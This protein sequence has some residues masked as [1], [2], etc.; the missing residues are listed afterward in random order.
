MPLKEDLQKII[1]GEI[2][3]DSASLATYSKDAS[4]FNIEPQI[5]VCPKDNADLTALIKY[6]A[7]H[8]EYSLTPRAAGTDMS[9]A[10]IGD[11]IILDM[12]KHFNRILEVGS[13][14]A[15][16][17]PGV[18]YRD[19]E[20][21]TLKKGLILPSFTSSKDICTVGGMVANNA[22]GER[23]LKY[24]QT[25]KYVKSLKVMFADGNEYI[26]EPLTHEQLRKKIEQR[27]FEGKIYSKIFEMVEQNRTI[28]QK[29]KPITHKNSTGYMLWSV[30]DGKTFDLTKLIVGSQGTL[31]II[32]E[33]EFELVKNNPHTSLLV[34]PLNSVD[35][36]DAIVNEVLKFAPM[37]FECY[38]DQ[39]VRY[40]LKF[41][42][43]LQTHFRFNSTLEVQMQFLPERLQSMFGGL[44]KLNLLAQF[45]GVTEQEAVDKA[46][47][48]QTA[49]SPFNLNTKIFPTDKSSEKYWVTRHESFNMLRHHS[50]NMRSAPFI[51]DII[52]RPERLPEFL[53]KLNEVIGKYEKELG[54]KRV[55]Y[56]VA[57]H[58]GD[59]NFHIIPLID[60]KDE[61][62][63]AAI[64]QIAREVF[65][66]VLSFNGSIAAEHNDGL[67][68][69]PF[70]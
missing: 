29:A 9:G 66:L 19:F 28:I 1:Q 15:R 21:E 65:E 26:V 20:I 16:V 58:I 50:T 41:L 24:G 67:V 34:I 48:A 8:P 44:P 35:K 13:D 2:L 37:A 47:K 5:I 30:W 51:D 63:R 27:D 36:V 38:D 32:T 6:V 64:P 69:G 57:G 60:I 17:Q 12:T 7:E 33:I 59:G 31:G 56:T 39:T 62:V 46:K 43:E 42:S 45:D 53:P 18:F 55:I 25:E 68:R 10:A 14:S 40:A 49:L 3:D 11:S 61:G 54:P 70:L 4:I 52:V 23:T 22:A